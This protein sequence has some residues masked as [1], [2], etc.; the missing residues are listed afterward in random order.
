[1]TVYLYCCQADRQ[2]TWA[3]CFPFCFSDNSGP[4][5]VGNEIE[6]IGSSS[7]VDEMTAAFKSVT[8]EPDQEE[9]NTH[10]LPFPYAP[11]VYMCSE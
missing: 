1:M 9:G 3:F 7:D 4:R 5:A 11:P 10:S 2:G 8:I 6:V